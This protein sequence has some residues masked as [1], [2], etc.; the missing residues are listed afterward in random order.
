MLPL[1]KEL[2]RNHV[3]TMRDVLLFMEVMGMY[4]DLLIPMFNRILI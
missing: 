3:R 2:N 1:G 4:N